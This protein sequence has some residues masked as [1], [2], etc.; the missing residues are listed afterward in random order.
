MKARWIT[1]TTIVL[2][3]MAHAMFAQS[4]LAEETEKQKKPWEKFSFKAGGFVTSLNTDV[5]IG[6]RGAGT[7]VDV[8]IEE[9]LDLD[10]STTVIRSDLLYRFGDEDLHRFDLTYMNLRRNSQKVLSKEIEFRGQTFTAGTT[11]DS[12]FN[13]E[14]IEGVYSY[15]F[16]QDDRIDAGLGIGVYVMPLEL[17]ISATG[18]G[19]QSESVTAPLPVIVFRSDFAFTPK[20]FLK[21]KIEIFYLE[22]DNFTGVLSDINI[23]LEYNPWE[24]FGFGVAIDYFRLGIQSN[25]E[26]YPNIDFVGDIKFSYTGLMLYGKYFF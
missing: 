13:L 11:V 3:C 25:G 4:V 23:A 21:E 5:R 10:S 6:L 17:G 7:G 24:H 16:F 8:N 9:A 12:F 19:A 1:L 14:I 18:F 20:L 22:L 26:D 2:L 15:S